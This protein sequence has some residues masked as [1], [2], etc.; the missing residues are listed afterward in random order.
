MRVN[1]SKTRDCKRKRERETPMVT[2]IPTK[3]LRTV[4]QSTKEMTVFFVSLLL[5]SHEIRRKESNRLNTLP[6]KRVFYDDDRNETC[7]ARNTKKMSSSICLFGNKKTMTQEEATCLYVF[8]DL[9]GKN[10]TWKRKSWNTNVFVDDTMR[11]AF[12]SS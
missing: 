7:Q 8:G 2:V 12:L 11:L 9:F 10:L 1:V 5:W 4:G 6:Y 3:E